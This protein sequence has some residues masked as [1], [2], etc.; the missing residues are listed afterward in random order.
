MPREL[1]QI[2]AINHE[3]YGLYG[4]DM[5]PGLAGTPDN[6]PRLKLEVEFVLDDVPG[7]WH[8]PE[9]LVNWILSHSY[10]TGVAFNLEDQDNPQALAKPLRRS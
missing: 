9:D 7:A 10:V 5:G 8:M 6:R 4:P 2:T 1:K 3:S